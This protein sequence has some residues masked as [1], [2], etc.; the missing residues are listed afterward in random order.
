MNTQPTG[1]I[2]DIQRYSIHD[3]QGIRTILFLKGCPLSCLWCANPESQSSQKQLMYYTTR[4]V[5]CFRCLELCPQCALAMDFET[6]QLDVD[7]DKCN[8]CGEC[9]EFCFQ[10]AL[11]VVGRT[12][13]VPEVLD[14][15]ERDRAFYDGSGGG[16]TLSGGEPLMQ[17]E[18]CAAVLAAC[19]RVGVSTAME[20]CGFQRWE[21]AWP[22]LELVD[23]VLLDIKVMDSAAHKR[24][25]GVPNEQILDNAR[26]LAQYHSSVTIRV[27]V[28]PACNDSR[29]NIGQIAAFTAELGLKKLH[30]L[31]YHRMGQKKYDYLGMNYA[32]DEIKPPTPTHMEALSTLASDYGL[33]VQI[34]G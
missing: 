18:F 14:V 33:E 17:P 30:L 16:I 7:E 25:T 12:A 32:L 5:S 27:P 9:E 31:P 19:K 15:V 10:N 22:A 26:K 20:T 2:F 11:A 8:L 23:E 21:R 34:G 24:L 28:V 6:R 1:T 4:C 13:T 3:G 29:E